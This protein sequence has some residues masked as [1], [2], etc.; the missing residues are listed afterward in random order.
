MDHAE[1]LQFLTT[2]RLL[3]NASKFS[4]TPPYDVLVQLMEQAGAARKAG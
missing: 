1:I 2:I 3:K 4:L